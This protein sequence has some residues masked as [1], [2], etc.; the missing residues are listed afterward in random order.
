MTLW[1]FFAAALP[2]AWRLRSDQR[3]VR[4]MK[5]TTPRTTQGTAMQ[6]RIRMTLMALRRPCLSMGAWHG[7]IA[8]QGIATGS[9]QKTTMAETA[10]KAP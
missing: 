8:P 7:Q 2:V 9:V 1:S 6:P 3:P 5:T 10:T 4:T